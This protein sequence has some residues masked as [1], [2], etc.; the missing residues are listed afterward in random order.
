[1]GQVL[2]QVGELPDVY[3]ELEINFFLLRRL[4]GVR[5]KEGEKQGKVCISLIEDLN[6]LLRDGSEHASY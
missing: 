5:S 3:S 2:G 6:V 4:L 1:V